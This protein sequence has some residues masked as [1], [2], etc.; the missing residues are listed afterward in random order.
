LYSIGDVVIALNGQGKTRATTG[1]LRVETTSNQSVASI[2]P[3]P[4]DLLSEYLH[5]D[6]KFR[7]QELRDMTGDKQR[8]GLNLTLLRGLNIPLPPIELQQEFSVFVK[9]VDVMK[10]KQ[11]SSQHEIDL[12]L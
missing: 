10:K 3:K 6:L 11:E 7:Y 9:Q 8:S 2:S 1:I 4:D 5:F 12:L